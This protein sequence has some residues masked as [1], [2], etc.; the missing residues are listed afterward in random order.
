MIIK[1][2]DYIVLRDFGYFFGENLFYRFGKFVL[3]LYIR[4]L[5]VF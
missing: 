2:I 5:G 4:V 1:F 3:D